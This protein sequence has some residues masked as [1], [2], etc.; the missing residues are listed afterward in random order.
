MTSPIPDV[1]LPP[2][3][4]PPRGRGRPPKGVVLTEEDRHAALERRREIA[5]RYRKEKA[6]KDTAKIMETKMDNTALDLLADKIISKLG[7]DSEYVVVRKDK[8]K[9]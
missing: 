2:L 1:S 6:A 9:I 8:L 3:P 4:P 7:L 5:R